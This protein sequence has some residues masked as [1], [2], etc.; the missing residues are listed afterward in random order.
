MLK[1]LFG[2]KSN[3]V[4]GLSFLGIMEDNKILK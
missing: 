4:D 3:Q 2:G 1:K